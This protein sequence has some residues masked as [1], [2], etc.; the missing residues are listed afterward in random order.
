MENSSAV[1]SAFGGI[2]M[3]M[4]IFG[5]GIGLVLIIANWKIYTKAG[6]PGWAC[7][8]PIYSTIVWLQI[9]GKPVWWI[10]LLLVPGVNIVIYIIMTNLLSK[11]YGKDTGFTVGLILLA[12]IFYCILGFGSSVYVG[13]GGQ[14]ATFGADDYQKP[15]GAQ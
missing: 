12:P 2:L 15:F 5:L 4:L 14:A 1:G 8:V 13:P 11:S 10:L 6:R 9:I 7:I 3:F